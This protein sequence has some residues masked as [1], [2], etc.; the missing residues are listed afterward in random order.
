MPNPHANFHAFLSRPSAAPEPKPVPAPEPVPKPAPAEAEVAPQPAPEPVLGTVDI[1]QDAWWR[2]PAA[3]SGTV[4]GPTEA[5][6]SA[7]Y[8]W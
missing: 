3:W 4:T 1:G 8:L 5:T 2:D 6:A 7:D